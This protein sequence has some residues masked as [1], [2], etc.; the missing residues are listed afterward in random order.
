MSVIINLNDA[1]RISL[2]GRSGNNAAPADAKRGVRPTGPGGRGP[3]SE[4]KSAYSVPLWE[5]VV[6]FLS[7]PYVLALLLGVAVFAGTL[8]YY[9]TS[10][11]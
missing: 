6:R 3:R 7:S 5:V 4:K 8:A 10:F 9:G 1:A 11:H 2:Y